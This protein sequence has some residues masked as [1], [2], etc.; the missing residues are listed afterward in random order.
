MPSRR[1][2]LAG[3]AALC[4][5]PAWSAVGNPSHVAAARHF[6][7]TFWL[8]GIG[9]GGAD[10]FA[11]PLPGR[12]HAAAAHPTRAEAV[13]FA[14][15]PGT[16][17]LV[18]DCTN[19]RVIAEL[20]APEGHHFYG[21]GVFSQ[22]GTR[23][24]TTENA[25]DL[26]EGRIGVWNTAAG[27]QRIAS[28]PSHGVGP[29]E[30]IRLPESETLV[31][32]NGGIETHPETGRAKL[33]LDT[34]RPNLSYLNQH[35]ELLEQL[36]LPSDLRLNSIRHIAASPSGEVAIGCQWQGDIADTQPLVWTHK[37]GERP[38]P[39]ALSDQNWRAFEGYIG[40]VAWSGDGAQ[41][42]ATSPRGGVV[43]SQAYLEPSRLWFASDVC[44][45]ASAQGGTLLS[46]GRNLT[47]L[48]I[49]DQKPERLIT[50]SVE[51]WDNHISRI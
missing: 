8:R 19:G 13:A 11:V 9:E 22:D 44:G 26:G 2:F 41:L 23:L 46:A 14:R 36:H 42:I 51:S 24:Y 47:H 43:L 40:S 18:L 4:A 12:G 3:A 33:N 31:V 27:Y 16:F 15:R 49:G 38:Q 37:P 20:K 17:A 21:H 6:D 7:G 29:H 28:L 1:T 32:A 35:G 30:I 25:Y 48:T 39:L 50:S 34:M 5:A 45:A 10:L